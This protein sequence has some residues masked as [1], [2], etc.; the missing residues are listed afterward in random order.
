MLP[1]F[2]FNLHVP[3]NAHFTA[4]LPNT[5]DAQAHLE[6]SLPAGLL[7]TCQT[8]LTAKRDQRFSTGGRGSRNRTYNLRFWRPTLCQLSYTPPSNPYKFPSG[9]DLRH[10]ASADGLAAFADGKAQAFFHG[11]RVDQLHGDRH[12]VAWHHHLFAFWQL[13]RTG[14]VRRA[15]VELGTVVVEEWRVAAAFVLGENVDLAGEVGVRLDGAGLAQHLAALDVFT[16]GAAQQDTD[17][18]AGLA[19]VEQLPEH[20]DAGAGGLLG[21]LDADDLDL[22][23][24]LD[25]AAL[26]AAGHH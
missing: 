15:E 5:P 24:D 12:V 25:H 3:R 1:D 22:F 6:F 17:V 16:L 10:D 20:L 14:H 18:V 26:D 4:P 8:T 13:D 9:N 19:L 23:A 11:D 7:V 21:V 2:L